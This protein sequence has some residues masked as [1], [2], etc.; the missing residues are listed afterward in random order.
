MIRAGVIWNQRSHRNRGGRPAPLPDDVLGIVPEQ[1]SELFA[2]LRRLAA[3][4]VDLVVIDGGDG[5]VREVLTRLPEAYGGRFPRLAILPNGKTNALALDLGVPLGSS[6]EQVLAAARAGKRPKGRHCLE[7]VRPGQALPERRGFLFGLGAFV[8]GTELAQK[9]HARGFFDNAAIGVTL[10]GAAARTLFGG[11]DEPW[12][13]GEGAELSFAGAARPWFLVLASTLKRFPLG[14]KPFGEPHEGLKVLSI[15]APPRRLVAAVP[16]ILQGRAP[17][18]LA[19]CGYRRDDLAA[20][21]LTFAGDFV[22]DGEIFDGG[23]MSLR[24]GP[25]LEFVIP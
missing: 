21:D 2:G 13:R 16:A 14:L 17:P 6:L 8:R 12:R 25:E 19:S 11:A 1:E 9:N 10:A 3:E 4:G 22:L 18:W 15:E 23:T 20:F 24:Q 7:V 5:T